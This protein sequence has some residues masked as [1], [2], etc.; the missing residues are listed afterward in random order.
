MNKAVFLDRDGTINIDHGYVHEI[1]KFQFIPGAKDALKILQ[2]HKFKLIIITSQSGIGR[3]YYKE[4][5]YHALMKYMFEELKKQGIKIEA[6]Y[7]CPHAPDAGCKCRKPQP[8]LINKA[9][10]DFNIDLKE[11]YVVGDKTADVKIGELAG[12][13]AVLVKTGK[14]GQDKAFKINPDF[15]AK[16]LNE[17]AKWIIKNEE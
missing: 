15:T 1:E 9:A 7:F 3:G 14:A 12:C 4:E 17:A 6:A 13:K 8:T 11:S 5:D 2:E 16:D 10:E